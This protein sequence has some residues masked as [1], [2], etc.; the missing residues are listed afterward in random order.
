MILRREKLYSKKLEIFK[1]KPTRVPISLRK[2]WSFLSSSS[3]K[4]PPVP[5][6]CAPETRKL[7]RE[8]NPVELKK[9]YACVYIYIYMCVCVCTHITGKAVVPRIRW[10]RGWLLLM[11]D[12]AHPSGWVWIVDVFRHHADPMGQST[13]SGGGWAR[14]SGTGAS[15]TS[16]TATAASSAASSATAALLA[17]LG[18]RERGF[19]RGRKATGLI[20]DRSIRRIKRSGYSARIPSNHRD[21]ISFYLLRDRLD[22]LF[23]FFF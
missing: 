13:A 22:F 12:T 9:V 8:K 20:G 5:C 14:A 18:P 10:L 15:R 7:F 16:A 11:M 3:S 4:L 23:F 17:A 6:A 21:E 1:R 2:I 19:L